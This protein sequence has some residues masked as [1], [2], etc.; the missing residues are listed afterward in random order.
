MPLQLSAET[1]AAM[2][3]V[4][5]ATTELPGFEPIDIVFTSV[6]V[7]RLEKD[8]VQDALA[9]ARDELRLVA[10]AAGAEAVMGCR[11]ELG[12]QQAASSQAAGYSAAVLTIF[13]YGTAAKRRAAYGDRF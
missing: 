11:F 9:H 3:K 7:L 10:V 8:S 13:A 2:A 1:R 6:Q 12:H 5:L 4:V